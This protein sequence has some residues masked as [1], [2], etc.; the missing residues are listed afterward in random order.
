MHGVASLVKQANF[1]L[2]MRFRSSSP[3]PPQA[4]QCPYAVTELQWFSSYGFAAFTKAANAGLRRPVVVI[5]PIESS[6]PQTDLSMSRSRNR[7]VYWEEIVWSW[8][9]LV[10]WK[11]ELVVRHLYWG[12]LYELVFCFHAGIVKG[13]VGQIPG[14]PKF[15]FR[16]VPLTQ[17]QPTGSVYCGL[18]AR[19]CRNLL[20]LVE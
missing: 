20:G 11:G 1:H 10:N 2:A 17:P 3:F 4:D 13:R 6:P 16:G 9:G 14:N 5:K 15:S 12:R 8:F 18:F 19:L 7:V